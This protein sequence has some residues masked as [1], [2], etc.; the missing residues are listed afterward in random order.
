M[1]DDLYEV[2]VE[3]NVIA[4]LGLEMLERTDSRHLRLR[5]RDDR[6]ELGGLPRGLFAEHGAWMNFDEAAESM[7][8]VQ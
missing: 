8:L 5:L 7:Q 1:V 6:F 4:E 3:E 2:K